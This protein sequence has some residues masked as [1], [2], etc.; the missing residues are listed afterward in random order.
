MSTQ[1]YLGEPP[2]NVKQWIIDHST[3]A[4]HADTWY[5]YAGDTEWRTVS[6]QGAFH[7]TPG[8]DEPPM[9]S[10]QIPNLG[11]VTEIEFGTDV[12]SIDEYAFYNPGGYQIT[13][14]TIPNSVTSIDGRAFANIDGITS[15]TF[16][17]RTLA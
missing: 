17:G 6:I 11:S 4:G 16:T 2:P 13:S 10:K 14:L 1:I 9:E 7:G 15:V 5:K 3:P 8:G 12:T